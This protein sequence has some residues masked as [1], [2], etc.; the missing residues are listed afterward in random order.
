MRLSGTELSGTGLSGTGL[1][2][3]SNGT[4]SRDRPC[5]SGHG[6]AAGGTANARSCALRTRSACQSNAQS[7][8]AVRATSRPGWPGRD[9]SQCRCGMARPVELLSA[10]LTARAVPVQTSQR[11]WGHAR[12]S[13]H[14]LRAHSEGVSP[15]SSRSRCQRRCDTAEPCPSAD[16]IP[17]EPGRPQCGT[18][19]CGS[20]V[21]RW[22]R[23][24]EGTASRV[25]MSQG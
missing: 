7:C 12:P 23:C 21:R 16:V 19:A 9:R 10:V 24:A 14:R 15:G 22:F 18:N 2:K 8:A 20:A 6:S 5:G 13:W 4:V 11:R 3:C 1:S 17:E 25:P